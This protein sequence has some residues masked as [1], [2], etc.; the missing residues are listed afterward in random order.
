M[1]PDVE[2]SLLSYISRSRS[3]LKLAEIGR[4][5]PPVAGLREILLF[6]PPSRQTAFA[7][8]RIFKFRKRDS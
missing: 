1:P 8:S 5:R 4:K 2:E 3:S 7:M 6:R